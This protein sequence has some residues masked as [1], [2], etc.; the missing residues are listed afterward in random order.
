MIKNKFIHELDIDLDI[1][2]LYNI[3]VNN[4]TINGL[5]SH[6]RIVCED[7][8][9]TTIKNK[10]PFLSSI[11]NVYKHAPGY[12]LPIHIDADRFCALNIPISNTENSSTIFYNKPDNVTLEYDS[13]RILNRVKTSVE[14]CFRFTLRKPTLINTT[15]P[16]NVV[17]NG[18]HTRIIISWSVL[19]PISF[20]E[21]LVTML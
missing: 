18:P 14:E 6:H 3:T 17:N 21:C 13:E 1:D 20:Q 8:Y 19:K 4:N 16:H 9:L 2:Y 7:A 5:P 11:F 10:Y 12:S 15:Y